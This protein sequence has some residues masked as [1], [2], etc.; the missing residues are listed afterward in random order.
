MPS[1]MFFFILK[2]ELSSQ[3]QNAKTMSI[4]QYYKKHPFRRQKCSGIF[5]LS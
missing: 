5:L 1:D 4:G 3:H 2:N